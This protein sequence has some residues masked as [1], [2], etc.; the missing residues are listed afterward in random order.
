MDYGKIGFCPLRPDREPSVQ[1]EVSPYIWELLQVKKRSIVDSSQ[2]DR[3]LPNSVWDFQIEVGNVPSRGLFGERVM[4]IVVVV[5]CRLNP[6]LSV[7][8]WHVYTLL[9][10]DKVKKV[11]QIFSLLLVQ[12]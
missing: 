1:G 2:L 12:E 10:A 8:R 7:Q 9:C 5:P 11:H 6:A 3:D 4:H